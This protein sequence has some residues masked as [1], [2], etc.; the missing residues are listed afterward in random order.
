[1]VRSSESLPPNW[2]KT[3]GTEDK[4]NTWLKSRFYQGIDVRGC[5]ADNRG[6]VLGQELVRVRANIYVLEGEGYRRHT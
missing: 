3:T 4:A 6:C 1:M 2:V 5:Y